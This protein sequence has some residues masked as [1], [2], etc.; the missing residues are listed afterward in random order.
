MKIQV[1]EIKKNRNFSKFSNYNF[2][3]KKNRNFWKNPKQAKILEKLLLFKRKT[4]IILKNSVFYSYFS[5]SK[6]YQ[7]QFLTYKS[8]IFEKS[9]KKNEIFRKIEKK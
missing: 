4:K 6:F 9:K 7:L 2:Q 1:L 8:K 3:K 5:I